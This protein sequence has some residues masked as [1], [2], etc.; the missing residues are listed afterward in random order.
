MYWIYCSYE[1]Y[2]EYTVEY[3]TFI[4]RLILR[5]FPDLL[6]MFSLWLQEQI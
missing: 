1:E 4:V 5:S 2:R 6:S 3:V